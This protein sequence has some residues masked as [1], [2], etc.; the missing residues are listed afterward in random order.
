M[1]H[2]EEFAIMQIPH[3]LANASRNYQGEKVAFLHVPKTAG[4]SLR[5]ALIDAMG[6]PALDKYSRV[7]NWEEYSPELLKLWP[8]LVGHMSVSLIPEGTHRGLT[9]FREPRARV[10][11]LFRQKTRAIYKDNPHV[12]VSQQ[13]RRVIDATEMEGNFE[14]WLDGSHNLDLHTWFADGSAL[15]IQ[16]NMSAST[17][18]KI[19][20]RKYA[21]ILEKLTEPEIAALLQKGFQKIHVAEWMHNKA[22]METLISRVLG[23]SVVKQVPRTNEVHPEQTLRPIKLS[24]DALNRLDAVAK[25]SA[26][27]FEVAH[28]AGLIPM[29]SK[30]EADREFEIATKRLGFKL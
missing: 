17:G 29:L 22:G 8:L 27:V 19:W 7:G 2:S 25:A 12:H 5:L 15:D 1:I 10:L 21:R 24:G 14:E 16:T 3:L 28:D 26:I 9:V 11:S 18:G 13:K 4:T 30:D 20:R 23:R 6:V